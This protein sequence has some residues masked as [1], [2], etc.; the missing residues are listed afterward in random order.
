MIIHRAR[1][2][3]FQIIADPIELDFPEKGRIGIFGTNESGKTTLM[4]AVE[5]ALYGLRRGGA[6]E[7]S[8]ENIITWGK[9]EAEV[10]VEF[11]SGQ[12]RFLLTRTFNIRGEHRARLIPIVDG[13]K[14]VSDALTS[15]TEIETKVE[16]ITGMDRESFKK[17]V[18]IKQKDLDALK[19]LVKAKREQLVNKVMGIEIFDEAARRV[20][21][22]VSQLAEDI[23]S[24]ETELTS[25][26]ENAKSYQEKL[27][28]K[29]AL[30]VEVKN[31]EQ[32]LSEKTTTLETAKSTLSGYAWRYAF[33]SKIDLVASRKEERNRARLDIDRIER[34]KQDKTKYETTV[35]ACEPEVS[36]LE[37]ARE[38]LVRLE[39][40][41]EE[42]RA[43]LNRLNAMRED[44]IQR[45]NLTPEQR[46]LSSRDIQKPKERQLIQFMLMLVLSVVLIVTG[47]LTQLILS[48]LGVVLVAIA[49]ILYV[50][51]RRVDT[52]L[53]LTA[54]IQALNKQIEDYANRV[55]DVNKQIVQFAAE[56]GFKNHI[57]VDGALSRIN[58]ELMRI[59]GQS[60]I[61]GVEALAQSAYSEIKRMEESDPS[62]SL[63][64][65]NHEIDEKQNEIKE[66]E[67]AKPTTAN[68][69]QYEAAAHRDAQRN[70]DTL[71]EE[72]GALE[73]ESQRKLGIVSQLETD[74]QN[75]K[76]DYD[77]LPE[78][79]TEH[80]V[81]KD[82]Q[83]ILFLVLEELGET[84]KKLRSQVMPQARLIINQILPILTDGRYSEFEITEDLKFKAHSTEA[85]GY[86]ERE[87]FSGGTQDQFLIAL[88]LAF[89]ESILDTR[90]M[91]DRYCLLMDECI[92][93]S[94]DQRKQGIFEVLDA[95]KNTFSQ[96]FIIAHED[97]SN[98]TDHHIVLSRNRRGYTEIRSKSW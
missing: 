23:R 85:D 28:Q 96:I 15:L 60:S 4:E 7:E 12:D 33:N 35:T 25:V 10:E 87:I 52:V 73:K 75:L 57:E 97:I 66:L 16:Q 56:S 88:R 80:G 93:S 65:L 41:L 91:A 3:G 40:A 86:K 64:N 31:L 95:M 11:T 81:L 44:A 22:D 45:A 9:E 62:T 2:S 43:A 68:N 79:E 84:S 30:N 50:R 6:A 94:D 58:E 83:T 26:R 34:L 70:V 46:E 17:L 39:N 37:T 61:Q 1:V 89:T 29:D 71:Q 27:A 67:K 47:V 53:S 49:A 54:N 19:G 42:H 21:D 20:K 76:R 90:V 92:S 74:L 55:Q 78:L 36:R 72:T 77:R 98:L 38:R 48:A 59:T 69:L 13:Q 32:Q 18:Y 5:Y 51:Y 14:N 24:K 63:Q 8:R 82:K